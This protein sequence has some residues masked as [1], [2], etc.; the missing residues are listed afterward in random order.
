MKRLHSIV[1]CFALLSCVES[2]EER[3]AF[4]KEVEAIRL[5]TE[6]L[7]GEIARLKAGASKQAAQEPNRSPLSLSGVNE[8]T[9]EVRPNALRNLSKEIFGLRYLVLRLGDR[10]VAAAVPHLRDNADG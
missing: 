8:H 5:A 3:T 9:L 4:K 1:S 6:V 2:P 10:P 7:P